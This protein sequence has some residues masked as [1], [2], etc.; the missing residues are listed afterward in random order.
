MQFSLISMHSFC[1]ETKKNH[2]FYSWLKGAWLA[3]TLQDRD[4]NHIIV[5]KWPSMSY[6][7][8]L[9]NIKKQGAESRQPDCATAYYLKSRYTQRGGYFTISNHYFPCVRHGVGKCWQ[10]SRLPNVVTTPRIRVVS[11]IYYTMT[12]RKCQVKSSTW[13]KK[14][15]TGGK[16]FTLKLKCLWQLWARKH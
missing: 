14:R 13:K 11:S 4:L 15:W 3:S 1:S 12:Q 6:S 5:C 10:R 7:F 16:V 2:T 9:V 8:C